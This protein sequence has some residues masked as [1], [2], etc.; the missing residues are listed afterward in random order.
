MVTELFKTV[1]YNNK[2][3]VVQPH[4]SEF[5]QGVGETK[6]PPVPSCLFPS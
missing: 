3:I 1:F 4:Y 5:I 2:R 6:D